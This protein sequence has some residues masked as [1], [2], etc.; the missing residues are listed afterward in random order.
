[1]SLYDEIMERMKI[2]QRYDH[3][4]AGWPRFLPRR[5]RAFMWRWKGKGMET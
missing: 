2:A 4:R 3:W 1:M 5:V